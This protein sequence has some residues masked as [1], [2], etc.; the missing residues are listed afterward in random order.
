M[1]I[2]NTFYENLS[3]KQ[4]VT[5]SLEAVAR[6]DEDEGK[7]L[8]RTC[9]KKTYTMNDDAFTKPIEVF[10]SLGMAIACDIR[11]ALLKYALTREIDLPE[12]GKVFLQKTV[13][14]TEAWKRFALSFGVQEGSIEGLSVPESAYMSLIEEMLPEPEEDVVYEYFEEWI[15]LT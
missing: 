14:L 15:A 2:Q 11:E 6:D 1:K 13:N 3:I 5:L 4:R 9:P 12:Q 7:R 10:F 8:V